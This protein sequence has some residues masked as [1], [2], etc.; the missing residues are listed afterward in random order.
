MRSARPIAPVSSPSS[1]CIT[2]APVSESPAMIARAIG[3]APRQRG[4]SEACRLRQ[5]KRG[6]SRIGFGSNRPYATTTATSTAWARNVSASPFRLCGCRTGM[7][8]RAAVSCTGERRSSIPRPAA[9]GR[10]RVRG[11]DLV[12]S[13]GELDERR[14]REFGSAHKDDAHR[15]PLSSSRLSRGALGR[16]DNDGYSAASAWRPSVY[17]L[18]MRSRLS[19]ERWSMNSTPLM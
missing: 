18:I 12:S 13:A 6:V 11:N 1:I 19:F 3:A 14:D 2:I 5:P 7:L 9:R 4:K 10:T 16:E 17:F 8:R 15:E